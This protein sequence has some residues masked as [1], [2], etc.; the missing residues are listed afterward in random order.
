[1]SGKK[2][3]WILLGL[4][5]VLVA[6]NWSAGAWTEHSEKKEAE[7]AEANKIYLS[8]A[9][10]VTAYSY[11]DGEQTMSFTKT[12]DTWT[13][14]ADTEIRMDQD[15][16]QSMADS[17]R[18]MTAVRELED[19]DPLED[20]GLDTPA[21]EI[22]CQDSD[23]EETKIY[24]GNGAGENYYAT[25]GD[26]GKVY[27]VSAGFQ[28]FLQFDL[29]SLVQYDT[30]PSIGTGNLKKVTVT[31][32]EADTIYQDEDQLGE[33]AGGF[34]AMTLTDCA[35]YHVASDVL[36]Q[37]GLDEANRITV[38]AVYTDSAEEEQTF[39]LYVGSLETGGTSRYVMPKGSNMVYRVSNAIVQNLMTVEEMEESEK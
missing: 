37:Y 30:V 25:V 11:T 10:N 6:A 24:I 20:Y 2:K 28:D 18:Q 16:A 31:E 5:L 38:T 22:L 1:M 39:C 19:P 32:N 8:D 26:S 14:D 35:D 33:L 21:Y 13:Y 15:V 4:I 27:T 29:T 9:E 36:A 34:G 12:E 3:M 23:G 7:E 17:I